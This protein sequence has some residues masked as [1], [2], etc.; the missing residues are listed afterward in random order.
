MSEQLIT[1]ICKDQQEI[2]TTSARL[3]PMNFPQQQ[4][5]FELFGD[6]ELVSQHF[7]E[8]IGNLGTFLRETELKLDELIADDYATADHNQFAS[9][10][11]LRQLRESLAFLKAQIITFN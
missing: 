10:E 1:Y 4:D 3:F 11:D 7:K 5:P 6:K 2:F 8:E 9:L